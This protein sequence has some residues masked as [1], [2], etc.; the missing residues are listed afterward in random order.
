MLDEAEMK[1]ETKAIITPKMIDHKR[2][3]CSQEK[4]TSGSE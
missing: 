4:R 1:E 3:M 2:A